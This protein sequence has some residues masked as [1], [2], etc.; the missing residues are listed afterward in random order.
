MDGF[1]CRSLQT[2]HKYVGILATRA[3]FRVFGL[4][5]EPNLNANERVFIGLHVLSIF[6]PFVRNS[7]G[8]VDNCY[9][10]LS[11]F[12]SYLSS[13]CWFNHYFHN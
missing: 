1:I 12:D 13:L 10:S 4:Y 8:D 9:N 5:C 2:T 6:I 3:A 7:R 11:A